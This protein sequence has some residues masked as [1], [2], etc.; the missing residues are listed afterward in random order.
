MYL[1]AAPFGMS[2][3]SVQIIVPS[4]GKTKWSSLPPD[5]ARSPDQTIAAQTFFWREVLQ[6]LVA[7]EAQAAVDERLHVVV[8]RLEVGRR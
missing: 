1:F 2:M 5:D 3:L 8:D 7:R 6:V 4:S